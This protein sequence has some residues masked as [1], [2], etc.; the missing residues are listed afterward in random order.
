MNDGYRRVLVWF[1]KRGA[2]TDLSHLELMREMEEAFLRSGLP[3]RI[4]Q[5]AKSKVKLSF[6]TA[7]PQ[8]MTSLVEM[9]ETQV[10]DS[11]TLREVRDGLAAELPDGIEP[12]DVDPVYTG[13][14]IRVT[15]VAYDVRSAGETPFPGEALR[16]LVSR[17]EIPSERR[18]RPVDL[19]VFL[20]KTGIEEDRAT[21]WIRWTDSGT[22]R[23]E[24]FL[25]VLELDTADFTVRKIGMT[26]RTSFGETIRRDGAQDTGQ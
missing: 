10:A 11:V 24:D 15:E 13:E 22:A 25:R 18:G 1:R 7:L 17:E 14:K 19:A 4:S 2:G 26:L 6:P 20:A 8:G 12:F 9:M 23:P 21:F 16:E 5:G 3:V